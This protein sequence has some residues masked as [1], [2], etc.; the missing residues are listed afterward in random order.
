MLLIFLTET[1][2]NSCSVIPEIIYVIM[3]INSGIIKPYEIVT[4]TFTG[5]SISFRSSVSEDKARRENRTWLG[6][7]EQSSF[8]VFVYSCNYNDT[9][10]EDE[11]ISVCINPHL[12]YLR[13]PEHHHIYH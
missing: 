5:T 10:E 8:L 9:V 1:V 11:D 13:P 3:H 12:V 6:R 4:E 2:N 7:K